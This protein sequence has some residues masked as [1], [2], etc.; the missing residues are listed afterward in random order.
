MKARDN[1]MTY[2]EA[3]DELRVTTQTIGRYVKRKRLVAVVVTSRNRFVT[4][5]SVRKLLAVKSEQ[6]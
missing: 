3:A 1:L 2:G 5:A 6:E 4:V